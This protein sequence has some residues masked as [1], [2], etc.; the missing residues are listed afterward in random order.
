MLATTDMVA[1]STKVEARQRK[2]TIIIRDLD[3]KTN[4]YLNGWNKCVCTC[5][6]HVLLK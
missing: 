5:L 4:E 6:A 1:L 2:E 3:T